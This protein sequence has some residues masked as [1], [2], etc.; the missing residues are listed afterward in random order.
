VP[1]NP[2]ARTRFADETDE[3]L[4][5]Y[6]SMQ[7]DDPSNAEEA[8]EEFF[9]RHSAYVLGVCRRFQ[10]VLG[11]AGAEDLAQETLI[12]AYRK[13]H[14]FK[15]LANG[16]PGEARVRIRAWLGQIANR[17][18]LTT[19]RGAPAV[20]PID[21][22]LSDKAEPPLVDQEGLSPSPIAAARLRLMREAL[23][24]LTERERD[25]LL[26][27]FAWYEP[28]AGCHRMPTQELAALME[29]YQTTAVNIR[30]IRERALDKVQRY[31]EDQTK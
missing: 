3:D 13:A 24:T 21:E 30:K 22:G 26:A 27:S 31:I 12:R 14:T 16:E 9:Y 8:W 18:F 19:L 1:P 11:N 4:L 17:L 25:V 20:D 7:T 15:P 23:R 6:M 28:G 10:R 29:R 5:L 2:T